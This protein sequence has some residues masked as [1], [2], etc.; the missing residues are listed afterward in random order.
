MSDKSP[1][2]YETALKQ[3]H[4]PLITL[5]IP[6]VKHRMHP[7][8]LVIASL[9]LIFRV[10]PLFLPGEW[11]EPYAYWSSASLNAKYGGDGVRSQWRNLGW[12]KVRSGYPLG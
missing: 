4:K 2:G 11:L 6:H 7:A 8:L 3:G 12:W 5:S 9:P 10:A 1:D